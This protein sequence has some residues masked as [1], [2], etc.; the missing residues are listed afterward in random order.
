VTLG[1]SLEVVA[2]KT[3]ER[4]TQGE[5]NKCSVCSEIHDV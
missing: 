1:F 2:V 4:L 5:S 3:R